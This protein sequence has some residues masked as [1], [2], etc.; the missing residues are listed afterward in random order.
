[1]TKRHP[2]HS[3]KGFSLIEVALTL[4]IIAVALLGILALIPGALQLQS[5]TAQMREAGLLSE[6]ILADLRVTPER[7]AQLAD[8]EE[9]PENPDR[10]AAEWGANQ[11]ELRASVKRLPATVD[12]P[13]GLIPIAIEIS[14]VRSDKRIFTLQA[15]IPER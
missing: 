13:P 6:K 11:H 12:M 8:Y 4:F 10:F 15:L 2:V 3:T 5:E 9:G 7:L 1:M 14:E